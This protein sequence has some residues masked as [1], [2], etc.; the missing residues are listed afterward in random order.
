MTQGFDPESLQAQ[1]PVLRRYA[2]ALTRD[3]DQAD[4]L[5]Q[6][7]IVRAL[8]HMSKFETGTNLKSWLFTIMHNTFCDGHRRR[9]RQGPL[10]PLDDWQDRL[11]KPADQSLAIELR[12]VAISYERLSPAERSLLFDVGVKGDSYEVAAKRYGTAVGTIKSR[13]SRA[14]ARLRRHQHGIA[15]S[16]RMAA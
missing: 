15:Q 2:L 12:E 14:R 5:V 10:V 16:S 13:L 11:S 6:D 4:D 7:C 8:K 3:G 9:Q 1:M